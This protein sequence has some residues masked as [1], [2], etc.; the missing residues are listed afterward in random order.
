MKRDQFYIVIILL[1][2]AFIYVFF[3]TEKILIT[4]ILIKV[5][6]NDTYQILKQFV[7]SQLE[8]SPIIIYSLP[9][10]LWIFCITYLSKGF[11][12][13]LGTLRFRIDYLPLVFALTVEFVQY[14]NFTKG[15]FDVY[16]I[17]LAILFWTLAVFRF[18]HNA[19]VKLRTF[20]LYNKEGL[21]IF[22]VFTVVILA[23]VIN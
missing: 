8:L 17:V 18:K 21:A 23:N 2:C 14:F 10:G 16:D 7:R 15:V 22:I 3:R 1:F 6:S 11:I 19:K 20:S 12:L 9:G 4:Q 13:K 5:I